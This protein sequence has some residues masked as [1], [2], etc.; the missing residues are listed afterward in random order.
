MV[1]IS[2]FPNGP[3][4]L[5]ARNAAVAPSILLSPREIPGVVRRLI[6]AP[7][8]PPVAER[9]LRASDAGCYGVAYARGRFSILPGRDT[10]N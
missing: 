8:P 3:L 10:T 7:C 9:V 6:P 2:R 5:C 1:R 4:A